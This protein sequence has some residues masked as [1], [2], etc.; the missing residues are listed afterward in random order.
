M[1]CSAVRVRSRAHNVEILV[2]EVGVIYRFFL[3]LC[4]WLRRLE[5]LTAAWG[6]S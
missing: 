5:V 3:D 4:R 6:G 2:K 1:R